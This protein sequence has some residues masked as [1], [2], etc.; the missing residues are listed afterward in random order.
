MMG[1]SE[2]EL[3]RTEILRNIPL[4]SVLDPVALADLAAVCVEVTYHGGDTVCR[5]GE[6]GDTLFVVLSGQLEVWGGPDGE[7]VINRLGPGEVVG[8]MA[9]LSGGKRA[10]TVTAA[11]NTQLLALNRATFERHLLPNPKMIEY[12]SRLLCRRL[13]TM[14]RGE[15][16]ARTTTTIQVQAAG[17]LKGTSFV[18][19]ALAGLLGAHATR[20]VVVVRGAKARGGDTLPSLRELSRAPVESIR[21]ALEGEGAATAVLRVG[22]G[23]NGDERGQTESTARLVT[24]LGDR[25]PFVVLDLGVAAGPVAEAAAEIADVVIEIVDQPRVRT[26]RE[27]GGQR[28]FEVVNLYNT[29]SRPMPVN[30]CEPFVLPAAADQLDLG[31][32]ALARL[33]CERPDLPV[34]RP[35]HRLARKLLGASVGLALGGGAAFGIAHLGV[36]KVLEDNR[37]PIDLLAGCSM[38]SIIGLGYA[39]GLSADEMIAIAN[40]IGTKATT[41]WAMM[42]ISITRPSFLTGERL[43]EIFSPL[44][45]PVTDFEQLLVP[46]RAVATDIDTGERVTIGS[47]RVDTAFRASS[48]VPMLWSPVK[49]DGRVL[50]DG[51]VADPVP[52]EVVHEMGADLCIA[53]NVVPQLRKGVDTM[54]SRLYR[55]FT[56]INPLSYLA[57]SRGMPSTFDLIMNS[58]QT[59]QYE[60]GNFKAI[61]ADVRINPDCSGFTWIEFYRPQELIERGAEA[62][63][64]ALP[65]IKRLLAARLAAS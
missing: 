36:L 5:V 40:R 3:E 2:E 46:C 9:L 13:A 19:S 54:L 53:I 39:A 51:G 18:A 25:F 15:V 35:L 31:P 61:S 30:H 49:V 55:R 64:R 28:L 32:A 14:A 63:E 41:M 42:D 1:A 11:R 59:L 38:G 24:K 44:T 21:G 43:V 48:A 62:A 23:T 58:M 45:G 16:A 57:D 52:A 29:S 20:D 12:F 56:A 34:A 6:E 10:A 60:L 8:E 17:G 7:R 22:L 26:P 33:V 47:G 37:V 27:H 4:F 50:V 65:D